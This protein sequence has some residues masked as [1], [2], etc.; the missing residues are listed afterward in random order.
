MQ[1]IF[2]FL[3]WLCGAVLS[4]LINALRWPIDKD[5]GNG[6][7]TANQPQLS[8]PKAVA[9]LPEASTTT[10]RVQDEETWPKPPP[11]AVQA[12]PKDQGQTLATRQV[13]WVCPCKQRTTGKWL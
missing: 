2:K 5:N 1:I 12:P 9:W 11:S 4:T 7:Y 8:W 10:S 6:S 3:P 13:S